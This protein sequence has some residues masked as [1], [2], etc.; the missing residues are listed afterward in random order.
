MIFYI[1]CV[2]CI[3]AFGLADELTLPV[4]TCKKSSSSDYSACLKDAIKE[5]WPRF[6]NGIPEFGFPPLDPLVHKDES[7]EFDLG[8]INV[9]LNLLNFTVIGLS[10]ID[11]DDVIPS[12]HDD[13]V[14]RLQIDIFKKQTTFLTS[15]ILKFTIGGFFEI[16]RKGFCEVIKTNVKETWVLTGCVTNDVWFVEDFKI[17]NDDGNLD[18]HCTGLFPNKAME[19]LF[20]KL[21]SHNYL[22]LFRTTNPIFDYIFSP[23]LLDY[24]NR[25]LAKVPFSVLFP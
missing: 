9:K 19:N 22:E 10:N 11:F 7:F 8:E 2:I 14:F 5:A 3:A 6:V 24:S 18:I 16:Q 13:N 25:F 23:Y 15:Y 12:L 20:E 21:I 4:D 17:L 1:V